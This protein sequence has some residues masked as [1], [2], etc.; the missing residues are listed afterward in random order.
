MMIH[1][2]DRTLLHSDLLGIVRA[3]FEYSGKAAHASADPW[4][5]VNALDACIQTFNAVSMLR[6][7]MRPSAG[8]TG[9]S[10]M[11]ALPPT[12]S[13][14]TAA[15]VFMVRAPGSTPCGQLY[16]RVVACAEGAARAT[17]AGLKVTQHDKVYE[18][19]NSSRLLDLFAANMKTAGL[20]EG[21]PEPGRLGSSDIGNVSQVIPAIQP[22][23]AIAP[24]GTAIHTREFADAAVKPMARAGLLAAA[25]TMA[26]TT[27]DLLAEPAR[28]EKARQDFSER[29]P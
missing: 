24:L 15:A 12:S 13:P 25:K 26:M 20:V 29:R 14:S 6:Q 11:A 17:G 19:L 2:F 27:F 7:Q 28:V 9:S 23:V 18:P 3:T 8:F 21:T 10:P 22:M 1:G 5:G 4:V 16:Q